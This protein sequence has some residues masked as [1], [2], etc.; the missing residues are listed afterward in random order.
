MAD[1]VSE[2]Q[3][4]YN[5]SRIRSKNTKPEIAVRS[6]LHR[7]GYRFT[8]NGPKTGNSWQAG[9]CAAEIQNRDLCPRLLLARPQRLQG[10]SPAQNPH[11]L[12]ESKNRGK[13]R[14]RSESAVSIETTRL[15]GAGDLGV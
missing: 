3:R 6:M 14:P 15:E 4:S 12:V 8:V 5:M 11:G 9:Y 10:F 13:H 2:A 1:I 7:L